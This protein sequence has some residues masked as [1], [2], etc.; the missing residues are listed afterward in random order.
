LNPLEISRKNPTLFTFTTM[1][2]PEN[3][4]F[5][6]YIHHGSCNLKD[7]LFRDDDVYVVGQ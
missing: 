7:D 6:I 2:D 4:I 1:L 3:L 5:S